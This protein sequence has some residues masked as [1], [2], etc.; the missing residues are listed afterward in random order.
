MSGLAGL[1]ASFA[2]AGAISWGDGGNALV[3]MA[4]GAGCCGRISMV[5]AIGWMGT[6]MSGVWEVSPE[7]FQANNRGRFERFIKAVSSRQPT[8][9]IE[10][11]NPS[12]QRSADVRGR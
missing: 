2:F 4:M 1:A 8:I 12:S 7:V 9:S 6:E 5:G 3:A 11:N 10:R